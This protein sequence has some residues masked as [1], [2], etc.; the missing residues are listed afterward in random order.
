M[1]NG[2]SIF[3]FIRN[4][5][6][7]FQSSCIFYIPTSNEW[8]FLLLRI[9]NS[10]QCSNRCVVVL[11]GFSVC[12]ARI[13]LVSYFLWTH[14]WYTHP[15]IHHPQPLKW[16]AGCSFVNL[17]ANYFWKVSTSKRVRNLKKVLLVSSGCYQTKLIYEWINWDF[18][19][20][21]SSRHIHKFQK[22]SR[23]KIHIK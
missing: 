11:T 22:L 19:Y 12:M 15:R 8:E 6:T 21:T 9:L 2:K 5:Q 13:L 17:W 16:A 3:S 4:R 10:I 18:F 7:I 20:V 23:W 14:G 1:G